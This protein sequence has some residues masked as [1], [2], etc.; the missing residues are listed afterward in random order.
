MEFRECVKESFC[1]IGK[2]GSTEDGIAFAKALWKDANAHFSEVSPV[3]KRD[4]HGDLAGIW[5][6]MTDFSRT[7]QPWEN[8]FTKGLYLAGV[9]VEPDAVPP[10][11]W[12]PWVVPTFEYVC[13]KN[14]NP[15]S[16]AKGLTCLK[17]N[18]FTLAGAVQEFTNPED[19][20]GYLYY[21]VR[22][23]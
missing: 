14:E 18:N 5:G 21:P 12:V 15:D 7:F 20:T 1:V 9:E 11:G 10:Q 8:G 23:L 16:F 4:E 19:G 2:E 6:L 13:I 3:A 17:E 22:R